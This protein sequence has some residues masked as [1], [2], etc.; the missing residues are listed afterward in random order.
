[1]CVLELGATVLLTIAEC[2]I[3]EFYVDAIIDDAHA[4][5]ARTRGISKEEDAK[6]LD[7]PKNTGRIWRA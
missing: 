4:K 5:N 1:M 7:L 6:V 2:I 3:Q